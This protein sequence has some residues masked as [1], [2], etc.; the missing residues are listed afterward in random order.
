VQNV[1]QEVPAVFTNGEHVRRMDTKV[2]GG[3][4]GKG[5]RADDMNMN[6]VQ[7]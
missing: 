3:V 4:L 1:T 7:N 6:V 2:C 5:D